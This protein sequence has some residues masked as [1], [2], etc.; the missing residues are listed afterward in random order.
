MNILYKINN[1]KAELVGFVVNTGATAEF[2]THA[3]TKMLIEQGLID[4]AMI[5]KGK[6]EYIRSKS[7]PFSVYTSY[8]VHNEV[9]VIDNASVITSTTSKGN[10]VKWYINNNWIKE[11]KLGYEGL[12][13]EISS[14]ILSCIKNIDYVSY[15]TCKI[16]DENNNYRDGCIC[17]NILARGEEEIAFAKIITKRF[18]SYKEFDK[19]IKD[20]STKDKIRVVQ[21]VINE[22]YRLDVLKYVA[23]SIN[24]DAIVLNEDRHFNNLQII[25]GEN[26]CRTFPVFDNGLSLLSDINAYGHNSVYTDIKRV[27]SKPFSTD[28]YTQIKAVRELG[29]DPL[30]INLSKLTNK[31]NSYINVLYPQIYVDR[32]IKVLKIRLKELEGKAWVKA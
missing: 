6:H 32:A 23:D 26:Y 10:Q 12:A 9:C 31:I 15:Y 16:K 28:F 14:I 5:V 19:V 7:N 22:E 17:K 21:R 18:T 30:Q 4:N 13:E 20:L 2:L 11:N 24:F 1:R 3:Q 25:K 8:S 27:K 29:V